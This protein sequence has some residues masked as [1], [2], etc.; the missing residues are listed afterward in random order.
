MAVH[1]VFDLLIK[2]IHRHLFCVCVCVSASFDFG[3]FVV[4]VVSFCKSVV[5]Q[6]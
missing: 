4:L 2:E 3:C 1:M 6:L 5:P